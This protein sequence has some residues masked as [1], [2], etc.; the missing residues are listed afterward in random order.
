MKDRPNYQFRTMTGIPYKYGGELVGGDLKLLTTFTNNPNKRAYDECVVLSKALAYFGEDEVELSP[1][2]LS[3]LLHFD[4][5]LMIFNLMRYHVWYDQT[6]LVIPGKILG[7][8]RDFSYTYP[9]PVLEEDGYTVSLE[10]EFPKITRPLDDDGKVIDVRTFNDWLPYTHSRRLKNYIMRPL[11]GSN[12]PTAQVKDSSLASDALMR[13]AN[14]IECRTATTGRG[15][16]AQE[17]RQPV[18]LDK[19]PYRDVS[20]IAAFINDISGNCDDVLIF[21]PEDDPE[22]TKDQMIRVTSMPGF[23]SPRTT[24]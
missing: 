7:C 9:E 3:K 8:S 17:I 23:Y 18:V 12:T 20:M 6:E 19:L 24:R 22:I 15:D 5:E 14:V 11:M 4:R 13:M 1:E 10:Q 2:N 21:G 16:E